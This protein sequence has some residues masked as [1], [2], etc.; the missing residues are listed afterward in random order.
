MLFHLGKDI[1]E[2]AQASQTLYRLLSSR[3][4]LLFVKNIVKSFWVGG[5][6]S[7]LAFLVA[8]S[9]MLLLLLGLAADAFF[10]A[11]RATGFWPG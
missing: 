11:P 10:H 8:L 5:T 1:L 9:T 6:L 2:S 3:R 7:T 4:F